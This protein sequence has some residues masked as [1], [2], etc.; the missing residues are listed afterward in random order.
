MIKPGGKKAA[1]RVCTRRLS[2][3]IG[4]K[5]RRGVI[6][7]GLSRFARITFKRNRLPVIVKTAT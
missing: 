4:P 5:A 1:G 7:S 2:F 6:A 3:V